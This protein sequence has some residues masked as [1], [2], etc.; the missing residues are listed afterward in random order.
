MCTL[1]NL[2]TVRFT[3]VELARLEHV[4]TRA[5][6]EREAQGLA[7]MTVASLLKACTLSFPNVHIGELGGN[8]LAPPYVHQI[9]NV[10]IANLPATV[11]T[12]PEPPPPQ[13]PNVHIDKST[14]LTAAE[15]EALL[16]EF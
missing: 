15:L 9:P 13:K 6:A 5:N 10:H 7:P 3:Q 14:G 16:A 11:P 2:A 1:K 4:L 8:G 12:E